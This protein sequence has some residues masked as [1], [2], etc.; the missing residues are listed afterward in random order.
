MDINLKNND[1]FRSPHKKKLSVW[2]A[3]SLH[4]H[5]KFKKEEQL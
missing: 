2:D 5:N 3:M 4:D 1:S